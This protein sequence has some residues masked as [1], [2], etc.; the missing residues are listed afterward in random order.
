MPPEHLQFGGGAEGTAIHPLVAA[1]LL[2]AIILILVLPRRKAIAAFL[3]P[4][5]TIPIEQVLVVGGFHFTALRFLILAGLMRRAFSRKTASDRFGGVDWAVVLWS[6]TAAVSFCLEYKETGAVVRQ[7]GNLVDTLGGFLVI[8][9]LIPDVDTMRRTFKVLAAI[10][11]VL[12]MCMVVEQ[13]KHVNVFG[14]IGAPIEVAVRNGQIRSGA[15]LGYLYAGAFAGALVPLFVWL[16]T[17]GK[18]RMVACA[19]L[20]G[21]TTM[22]ITSH[23]STSLLALGGGILGLAF[24]PLRKSMRIIRWGLVCVLV[25]LHLVMK[26]PVWAL[27][28]RIDLT[29]SSSGSQRYLLVDMTIRHFSDWWLFGTKAYMA[30]GWSSWDLCNQFVAVAL[31]GGLLALIFYVAIFQRSFSLLGT[32]RKMV[33][34]NKEQE[35]FLWCLGASLFATVVAHFGINYMAQLIMGV[36][37]LVVCIVV[38]VF[39]VQHVATQTASVPVPAQG[40]LALAPK[41]A[42]G[43][44]MTVRKM[45]T[46][47]GRAAS[48]PKR[49]RP[50]WSKA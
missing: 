46:E 24:W 14:F 27:I 50:L 23:S 15:T 28:Q 18:S 13:V 48:K 8:R 42:V 11:V 9:F 38:A 31:T 5:F 1:Y 43:P 45:K 4:F 37:T 19:G 30:W 7:S 33:E 6:V 10:C 29:G 20:I 34:G 16:G 3:F 36:F 26:A 2:I 32:A 47:T 49:E 41:S 40:H 25:A 44:L 17:A 22:V 39:E 35:W 12:G 21:A